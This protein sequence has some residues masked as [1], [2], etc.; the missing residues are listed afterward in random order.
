MRTG[1]DLIE[2]VEQLLKYMNLDYATSPSVVMV[3]VDASV[4]RDEK[5]RSP[6][7]STTTRGHCSCKA[8]DTKTDTLS[9]VTL[10]MRRVGHAHVFGLLIFYDSRARESDSALPFRSLPPCLSRA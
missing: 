5:R 1:N 4:E 8:R 6:E 7:D 10:L 3:L 2:V 9:M